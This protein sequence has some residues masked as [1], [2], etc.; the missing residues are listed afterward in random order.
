M[1]VIS[2]WLSDWLTPSSE[3]IRT[4]K[5]AEG[6]VG[7]TTAVIVAHKYKEKEE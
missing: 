2:K 4:C 7:K 6:S 5:V 1:G 3:A